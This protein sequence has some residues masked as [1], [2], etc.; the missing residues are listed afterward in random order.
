MN[1]IA[2]VCEY[3]PENPPRT[4]WEALQT[5]RFIHLGLY[6]EDGSGAGASLDRIDQYLYPIYKDDREEGRLSREEASEL[7]A[8]FWVKIAATDRIPP[9][10][11]KV[12]GAGY[13]AVPCNTGRCGLRRQRCL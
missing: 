5:V 13:V 10:L 12:S 8:T 2:D 9:G 11:V 3:V 6:L 7:L 1:T 4:F